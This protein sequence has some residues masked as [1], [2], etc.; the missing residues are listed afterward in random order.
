MTYAPEEAWLRLEGRLRDPKAKRL[1]GF[2]VWTPKGFDWVFR[3]F[4]QN[5]V[6]G[7]EMIVAQPFENRHVLDTIPDYYERL[8][9]SYS[10]SF[11]RQEVLGEYLNVAAG[12][13]YSSF[14]REKNLAECEL[15]AGKTV[16]WT[17]DFNVEPMC[18]LVAQ[19]DGRTVRVVDEIVIGRGTTEQACEEFRRRLGRST[20]KVVVYGD[21]SGNR[22]QTSGTSDYRI[23]REFF[24]R[25]GLGLPEM[26]VPASNPS[27]RQRV[28]LMNAKLCSAGGEV[29]LVVSP[30]CKELIRDLEEV[31]Y[32]PGTLV[33][34]KDRDPSRTHLSDAL[35]YLVWQEFGP[36]AP[37]GE[38]GRGRLF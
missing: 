18:S 6:A 7:Y 9:S 16:L 26:R 19:I 14:R 38:Q 28:E 13:V 23:V 29:E 17:L 2:G 4:R 10:D 32:V 12:L 34:D 5:P 22:M 8:K 27:V 1:C 37:V 3:R 21:A 31:T 33:V 24:R 20:G 30:R 35:G 11:Y 25:E 15:A 36:K